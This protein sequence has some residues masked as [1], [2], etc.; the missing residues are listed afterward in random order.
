MESAGHEQNGTGIAPEKSLAGILA[1]LIEER[2]QRAT[3][4]KKA[5][6]IEILLSRAGLSN[7]D[8]GAVTGKNAGAVR[9]VI[10]RAKAK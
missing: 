4:D 5:T 9:M 10:Q 1:L 3:G 8:I 2:E 7:S 6:K